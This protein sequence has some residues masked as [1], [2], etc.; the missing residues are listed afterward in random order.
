MFTV[1]LN[2]NK[3]DVINQTANGIVLLCDNLLHSLYWY[4]HVI[5]F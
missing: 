3:G 2:S 5:L 4:I 1:H